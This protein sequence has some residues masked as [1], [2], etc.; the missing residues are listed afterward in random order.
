[1]GK[2]TKIGWALGL[3][4]GTALG[5]L[6]APNKGKDLRERIKADIKKGEYGYKPLLED[7]KKM[8]NEVTET[9]KD[10]YTSDH[11]QKAI[12]KGKKTVQNKVKELKK[13]ADRNTRNVHKAVKKVK[14]QITGA[15]KK[16]SKQT[17]K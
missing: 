4:S 13:A 14:A 5:V 16:V 8:G 9:A 1:M 12:K 3:L 2:G 6:F 15:A 17:K 7:F 11:V 10:V